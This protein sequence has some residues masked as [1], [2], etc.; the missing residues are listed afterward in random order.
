MSSLQKTL[1]SVERF[2]GLRKAGASL[3]L[4][5]AI[6]LA[7][8]KRTIRAPLSVAA[9]ISVYHGTRNLLQEVDLRLRRHIDVDD[10]DGKLRRFAPGFFAGLVAC[11]I[12]PSH[13]VALWIMWLWTRIARFLLPSIPFGEVIFGS[14]AAGINLSTYLWDH[15]D[16]APSYATFLAQCG[17]SNGMGLATIEQI[18]LLPNSPKLDRFCSV[19]HPGESHLKFF[20]NAF[21][22]GAKFGAAIQLPL[23]LITHLIKQGSLQSTMVSFI[24]ATLFLGAYPAAAMWIM[25]HW[26]K[27]TGRRQESWLNLT[28]LGSLVGL[29]LFVESPTRRSEIAAFTFTHALLSLWRG[30]V[31]RKQMSSFRATIF[32][33][34]LF[35]TAFG[36]LMTVP[37]AQPSFLQWAVK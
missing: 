15:R 31:G 5:S 22:N 11:T 9:F 36:V 14:L 18:R 4:L 3:V 23:H 37:Q 12:D 21:I 27:L 6:Q 32:A 25:C 17:G 35:S 8:G 34:L 2:F 33:K 19:I 20:G 24:R 30:Q 29:T 13:A 26:R 7:R 10:L 16:L 1:R 28:I